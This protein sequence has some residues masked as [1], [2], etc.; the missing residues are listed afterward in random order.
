MTKEFG[1]W[2]LRCIESTAV[3]TLIAPHINGIIKEA[4]TQSG[5]IDEDSTRMSDTHT[6]SIILGLLRWCR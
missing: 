4:A 5:L 2:R 6:S 3:S 1:D